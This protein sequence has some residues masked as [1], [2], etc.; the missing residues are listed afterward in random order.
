MTSRGARL[1]PWHVPA[2][3]GAF[4]ASNAPGHDV[5]AFRGRMAPAITTAVATLPNVLP[6]HRPVG[7]WVDAR[8]EGF[9]LVRVGAG[10]RR[11]SVVAL[12]I[13][14]RHDEHGRGLAVPAEPDFSVCRE[15]LAAL[16]SQATSQG[17]VSLVARV[18]DRSP[19]ASAF[20]QSGFTV[21]VRESIY[22]RQPAPA[23]ASAAIEGLRPQEPA[24]AWDVQQLYRAITPAA[25]QQAASL[26][27][28]AWDLPGTVRRRLGRTPQSAR[29]VV[30]GAQGLD[31]WLE[32]RSVPRGPHE[33]A[34]MLHP[35]A[36]QLALPAVR[37]ALWRLSDAPQHPVEMVVREHDVQTANGLAATGFEEVS[38]RLVLAKHLAVRVT[39][40]VPDAA[41]DR[42]TS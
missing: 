4:V 25:V 9:G 29:Y 2:L 38:C 8:L 15:L 24:D 10:H 20:E 18:P 26:S 42:A 35:R 27:E 6:D 40:E 30:P 31:A 13:A 32:L 19:F 41:L 23:A 14:G 17:R 16:T 3:L 37:F 28:H 33:I 7:A 36:A 5:V 1:R 39:S 21:A 12:T 11:S 34:L 22:R